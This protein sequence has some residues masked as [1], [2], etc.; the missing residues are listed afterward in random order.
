MK[1][2]IHF[3]CATIAVALVLFLAAIPTHATERRDPPMM[4]DTAQGQAGKSSASA[5]PAAASKKQSSTSAQKQKAASASTHQGVNPLSESKDKAA[6]K[7]SPAGSGAAHDASGS[8][9]AAK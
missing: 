7:K 4:Q 9:S 5:H 3:Y 8:R 6:A 2:R 1:A